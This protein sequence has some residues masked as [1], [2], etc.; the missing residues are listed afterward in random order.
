[1]RGKNNEDRYAIQAFESSLETAQHSV[2]L[3]VSDGVGGHQAGEVAAEIAVHEITRCV[4]E[5]DASRPLPTLVEA[6]KSASREIR[7]QARARAEQVGMAATCVCAWVIENRL[8]AASAGDSRL[9][10]LRAGA[11]QQLTTDHTWIQEALDR[12]VITSADASGHPNMHV[13]RRY[14]GSEKTVTPDTQLRLQ[15]G[16]PGGLPED[17]QQGFPLQ[18]GD[19]LVLSTDGLTDLVQDDEIRAAFQNHELEQAIHALIDLANQRGGHDNITIAAAR[20]PE[21]LA[22]PTAGT[23]KRKRQVR[24]L[25][26]LFIGGLIACL[27]ILILIYFLYQLT[28]PLLGFGA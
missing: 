11:I 8:Y 19:L 15:T 23:G 21:K 20:L 18:P 13:I 5:S 17:P 14:L 12:G 25:P 2:L 24:Y 22:R 9:Y 6:I 1:M 3:V 10:L 16:P 26:L 27:A 28:N 7:T 4:A